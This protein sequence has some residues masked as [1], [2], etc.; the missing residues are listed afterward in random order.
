[1]KRALLCP[2]TLFLGLFLITGAASSQTFMPGSL[3]PHEGQQERLDMG[4]AAAQS[5]IT[6]MPDGDAKTAAQTALNNYLKMQ[7]AGRVRILPGLRGSGAL[8]GTSADLVMPN[9]STIRTVLCG[10]GEEVIY[11]DD[12]L[13]DRGSPASIGCVQTHEGAR[14]TERGSTPPPGVPPNQRQKCQD[15]TGNIQV[16]SVHIS[17]A[18]SIIDQGG[19]PPPL[20]DG[21]QKY[22]DFFKAEIT[23]M[24]AEKVRLGCQ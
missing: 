8:G 7:N 17:V 12:D 1:M 3:V 19:L 6:A 22:I 24:E 9:G 2:G 5:A 16:Y 11:L 21:L 20:R 23:K 13:V 15:L 18:K 4:T 14:T 10:I